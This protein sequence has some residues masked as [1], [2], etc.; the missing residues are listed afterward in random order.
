LGSILFAV[1][2]RGYQFGSP[3]IFVLYVFKQNNLPWTLDAVLLTIIALLFLIVSILLFVP[4]S[5]VD[6]YDDLNHC[7]K[8]GYNLHQRH[9]MTARCPNPQC[10]K[11]LGPEDFDAH[12]CRSCGT[13]VLQTIDKITGQFPAMQK[14]SMQMPQQPPLQPSSMQSPP[15]SLPKQPENH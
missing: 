13:D 8:C 1:S 14:S 5:S 15:Q 12:F 3:C 9:L 11:M 7:P 2:Y 10:A 4:V 6:K